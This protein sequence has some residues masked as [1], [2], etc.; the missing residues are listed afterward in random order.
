[1]ANAIIKIIDE[2]LVAFI[3]ILT[4]LG[5]VMQKVMFDPIVRD[6]IPNPINMMKDAIKRKES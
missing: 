1:V 5:L 2:T 4:N 3:N 6:V